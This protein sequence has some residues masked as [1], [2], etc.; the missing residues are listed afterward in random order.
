MPNL[1]DAPAAVARPRPEAVQIGAT[2]SSEV[3]S[4]GA[5]P[6]QVVMGRA[7]DNRQEALAALSEMEQ[8]NVAA[9][10]S[11]SPALADKLM[12]AQEA[13]FKEGYMRAL[14]G[15]SVADVAKDEGIKQIFGDG[16]AVRGARAAQ[17]QSAV[18][19]LD[20][21][22][23]NNMG[24][25]SRMSLD[26][27][28]AVVGQF[29]DSMSTGDSAADMLIAQQTMQRLPAVFDQLT[30]SAAQETQ[31]QA[32]V[33]QADSIKAYAGAL[34][35]AATAYARGEMSADH[36]ET[37][38]IQAAES[39]KPL[40]GQSTQ[41]WVEAM[42]GSAREH[43]RNGNFEM[44]NLIQDT[45]AKATTPEEQE[46]I[47][48]NI[49][50]GRADW[51]QNNPVSQSYLEWTTGVST[52]IGAGRYQTR[53]DLAEDIDRQNAKH[54]RETGGT[55]QYINNEQRGQIL[56]YWD[57]W[58][59]QQK[60]AGMK[61]QQKEL[62][63]QTKVNAYKVAMSVGSPG[64][65]D[66]SG[67]D[68]RSKLV[69]DQNVSQEFVIGNTGAATI[70]QRLASQGKPLQPLKERVEKMT[71]R[72]VA[73]S[74]PAPEELK[75]YRETFNRMRG[76][77]AAALQTYYGD[78]LELAE[79]AAEMEL[80]PENIVA[81]RRK[82]ET[83]RV[84]ATIPVADI[85][86]AQEK[87]KD[88]MNPGFFSRMMEGRRELGYGAQLQIQ[89]ESVTAFAQL[90]K[91]FPNK[92]DSDLIEMAYAKT[93][94]RK[95]VFG[96]Y[97]VN[98][99]QSGTLLKELNKTLNFPITDERDGRLNTILQDFVNSKVPSGVVGSITRQGNGTYTTTVR[100]GAVE[101]ILFFRPE[102]LSKAYD[103]KR[104]NEIRV[105]QKAAEE[106]KQKKDAEVKGMVDFYK[107]QMK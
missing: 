9:L 90:A 24:D 38:K 55:Q 91:Q 50:S 29:V 22:V 94:A 6:A 17:A 64:A 71:G 47:R 74:V 101:R 77:G 15:N 82:A 31:R 33:H 63:E 57:R 84:K 98:N 72:L 19:A 37:Y 104:T 78:N 1:I 39:L 75:E 58:D 40:P 88:L 92:P 69:I 25:L 73:G 48:K 95:D 35:G 14:Q 87:V 41:A 99:A 103:Q 86:S 16:A 34:S 18:N 106:A 42:N 20:Q 68:A 100:D 21:Y 67:I 36:F 85:I 79:F 66:A 2:F 43:A 4:R 56:A 105:K 8:R 93:M 10:S 65:M 3:A 49:E 107:T 30:R 81:L 59:Q 52:Q 11:L 60:E 13:K 54:A 27:Q 89:T 32:A 70:V 76:L 80:T 45:V 51:L 44:V 5:N 96:D 46:I 62:D 83:V 28:R 97:L 53:E 61:A 12:Q 102:E 23:Q 26:E 7:T